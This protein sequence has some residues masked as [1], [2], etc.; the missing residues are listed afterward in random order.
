MSDRYLSLYLIHFEQVLKKS[1]FKVRNIFS[2]VNK[3]G[4][5]ASRNRIS[6]RIT[7]IKKK[8]G[9][10]AGYPL[11]KQIP[12]RDE[13]PYSNINSTERWKEERHF[14]KKNESSIEATIW[15]PC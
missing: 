10:Q 15:E 11:Q 1:L 3:Y 4:Y 5:P 7:D 6:C 14:N 13:N 2:T 9:Y 12:L 8:A